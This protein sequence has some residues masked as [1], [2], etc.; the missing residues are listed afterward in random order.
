MNP[1]SKD[2]SQKLN[3]A[4]LEC[5]IEDSRLFGDS[6]KSGSEKQFQINGIMVGNVKIT[7]RVGLRWVAVA[8]RWITLGLMWVTLS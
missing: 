5:F 7:L 1:V 8:L 6:R 3:E 2:T 4:T